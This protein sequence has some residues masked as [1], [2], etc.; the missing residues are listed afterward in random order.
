MPTFNRAEFASS[1]VIPNEN[2]SQ[3]SSFLSFVGM[4]QP[5]RVSICGVHEVASPT[6]SQLH[7]PT[8]WIAQDSLTGPMYSHT[9][10]MS[11]ALVY[12]SS[13]SDQRRNFSHGPG[14]DHCNHEETNVPF[15]EKSPNRSKHSMPFLHRPQR[16][17]QEQINWSPSY[18][19]RVLYNEDAVSLL[20]GMRNSPLKD[21]PSSGS[22]KLP[23]K[24]QSLPHS[25][26]TTE[27]NTMQGPLPT[28]L[29]SPL[30]GCRGTRLA[31][32]ADAQNVNSLHCFVRAEL[33]ELFSSNEF[34]GGGLQR[35]S[36]RGRVGLRCVFCAHLSRKERAGASMSSF[37]PKSLNDIYR[38]VCTWQR[39]HFAKCPEVPRHVAQ[40]YSKLKDEDRSRGKKPYWV[41]SAL[42][43]GLRNIDDDRNGVAWCS[44]AGDSEGKNQPEKPRF[45]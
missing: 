4:S 14:V 31:M 24:N 29:Q 39:L 11:P 26:P 40:R 43:L 10:I 45:V 30:V 7:T 35:T 18:Q 41:Y 12:D 22:A 42:Q 3:V 37:F 13:F 9:K 5:K 8:H 44:A 32:P 1:T 25:D 20:L 28:S 33:L 19:P 27:S 23:L 34:A 6:E 15:T 21:S 38:G 2:N 16:A 17:H 36:Q